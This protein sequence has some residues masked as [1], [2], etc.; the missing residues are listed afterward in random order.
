ME[1]A[2]KIQSLFIYPI[3]SCRGIS[4]PQATVTQTGNSKNKL[5][6]FVTISNE[7]IAL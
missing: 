1:E 7:K 6:L 2:L 4:V 3:K 5:L